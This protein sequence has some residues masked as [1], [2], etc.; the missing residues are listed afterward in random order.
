[1][2]K[3]LF[4]ASA[5]RLGDFTLLLMRL[6]V[7]LFLIWGVWDNVSSAGRM[8]EFVDF[9]GKHGFASPRLMAPLSVYLQLAIGLAFVLGLFT[10]WAGILCAVHFAIAIAMVDRHGGMRGIFPAGCLIVI[11][12][13][14]ATYGAGRFSLD[15]ALRANELPR[16][17]GGVRLKK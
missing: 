12:L 11:G 13:Y 5:Q 10:R 8:H 3:F 15:A 2:R 4:L 17:T 16:T 1:M 14:L 7:G 9:L 6:F